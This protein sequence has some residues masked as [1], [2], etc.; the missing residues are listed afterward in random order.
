M[1][2]H[3]TAAALHLLVELRE[4]VDAYQR[5]G[6]QYKTDEETIRRI[7]GKGIR[8]NDQGNKEDEKSSRE[9][10]TFGE[11]DDQ[12]VLWEV[13]IRQPDNSIRVE[14]FAPASPEVEIRATFT[15]AKPYLD[16]P[17]FFFPMEIKDKGVYASRGIPERIAP[18]EMYA[19]R[20]WNE[21]ADSMTFLN[22]PLYTHDGAAINLQN[23][24]PVAN[25][26]TGNAK[27]RCQSHGAAAR[28]G[29]GG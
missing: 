28:G 12:I 26:G 10:I 27:A 23:D 17:V 21:K 3:E 8:E 29:Q 2:A 20:L 15:L 24:N 9:G 14:T 16:I 19:T 1:H 11:D 13:Y 7:R 4:A 6:E 18:H 22:K 25:P 5:L